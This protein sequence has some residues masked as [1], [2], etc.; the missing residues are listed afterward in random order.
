MVLVVMVMNMKKKSRKKL[1]KK[2]ENT[3]RFRAEND[4]R[5]GMSGT[6]VGEH[7]LTMKN[8]AKKKISQ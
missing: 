5:N 4:M 1:D 2:S 6:H 8:G 3:I 7:K